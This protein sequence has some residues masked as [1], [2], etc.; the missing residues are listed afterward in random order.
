LLRHDTELKEAVKAGKAEMEHA[1]TTLGELHAQEIKEVVQGHRSRKGA[2]RAG[3]A[4][5]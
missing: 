4:T 2:A 5:E 1:K 3:E